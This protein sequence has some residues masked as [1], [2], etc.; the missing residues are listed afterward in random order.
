MNKLNHQIS[1]DS[2]SVPAMVS[3]FSA[4][5]QQLDTFYKRGLIDCLS[6]SVVCEKMYNCRDFIFFLDAL[7]NSKR[8][9]KDME[10]K[11]SLDDLDPEIWE[12]TLNKYIY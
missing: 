10:D 1:I 9:Q 7:C 3:V 6:Y 2:D 8:V 11:V 4:A 12:K 5:I